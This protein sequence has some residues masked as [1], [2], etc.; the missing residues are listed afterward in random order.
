MFSLHGAAL[1]HRRGARRAVHRGKQIPYGKVLRC[2]QL[3]PA[4][5]LYP[6]INVTVLQTQCMAGRYMFI[7]I[8]ARI[9]LDNKNA[10]LS[11]LWVNNDLALMEAGA[12][13]HTW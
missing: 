13:S 3:V 11:R 2:R 8:C 7:P 10:Q 5:M 4:M 12:R 1:Q 6:C 9:R